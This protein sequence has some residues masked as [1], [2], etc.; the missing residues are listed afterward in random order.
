ME[1][2]LRHCTSSAAEQRVQRPRCPDV[3][4]VLLWPCLQVVLTCL[5]SSPC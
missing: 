1:L 4:L 5:W 3:C 2:L